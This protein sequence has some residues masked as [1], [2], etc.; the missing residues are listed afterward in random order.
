MKTLIIANFPKEKELSDFKKKFVDELKR[1]DVIYIENPE[2]IT[3][4]EEKVKSYKGEF[5]RAV[6]TTH[7]GWERI[8][9]AVVRTHGGM[10]RIPSMMIL[11]GDSEYRIATVIQLINVGN[12]ESVKKIHLTSCFI[13]SNFNEIE[14]K[15]DS[16]IYYLGLNSSLEDDQILFL[17]GDSYTGDVTR[18]LDQR[19]KGIVESPDYSISEAVLDSPESVSVVKKNN[20][21]LEAF[22]YQPFGRKEEELPEE[23]LP[24]AGLIPYLND[25]VT[26]VFKRVFKTFSYQPSGRKEEEF[27]I[28]ALRPY[29]NDV[30]TRARNF[31]NDQGILN[32][33]VSEQRLENLSEENLNQYLSKR[34]I[35]EI[36]KA[37]D[38][39]NPKMVEDLIKKADTNIADPDGF[40][41]LMC[42][43][44]RG[45]TEIVELLLKNKKTD[46]NIAG[47]DGWTALMFAASRGH[48]EIVELLLE[49]EKTNPNSAEK[50][51]F[52]ALMFAAGNGQTEVAKL[53]LE[54]EKQIQTFV[55]KMVGQL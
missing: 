37:I 52:S 50:D 5:D 15:D 29:L 43:A 34:F 9:R 8:D 19:L 20:N 23:E 35:R 21:Q 51:G 1:D 25:V 13:G 41:A 3:L 4:L 18:S 27:S 26:R 24:I 39:N 17:H 42:A 14:Q 10:E 49:N 48:T 46:P 2:S 30:V 33:N 54:N 11:N 16:S 55:I 45:Q 12:E 6:V 40:T 7:G 22:S 38:A 28:A 31:E 32:G 44:E 47:K 53:L 36:T